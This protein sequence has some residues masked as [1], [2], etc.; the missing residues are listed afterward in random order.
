MSLKP[1]I[2]INLEEEFPHLPHAPIVEAV[3]HWRAR[4]EKNIQSNELHQQFIEE[5][6]DYPD[7]HDQ[8]EVLIKTQISSAESSIH[9]QNNWHGFRFES[10]DKLHIA[11]FT[12]NGFVFSRLAPY[13][14][15]DSF[16]SEAQR[17]W[18]IYERL[19][20]PLEIDRLGVRFINRITPVDLEQLGD[21][22]KL[23]P[24]G[25]ASLGLP[26]RGFMRK[27]TFDVPGHKYNMNVIQTIQPSPDQSEGFGLILDIDVF[28][29]QP[30]SRDDKIL[31][32]RLR[33]MRWLKDKAFFSF[34]SSD[35]IKRFG[36]TDS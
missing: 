29:T 1:K 13:Q 35:A 26:I 11:Q 9:Q 14:Q 33:E 23:P 10:E 22:L 34:L 27:A 25:P 31:G 5:L 4:P 20:A 36:S 2:K 8:H 6:P 19:A 7:T 18:K 28:T 3:I 17:L 32:E 15:W 24:Q 21:Y 16:E 30:I 12:R